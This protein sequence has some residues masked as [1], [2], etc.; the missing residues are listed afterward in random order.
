MQHCSPREN[1]TR[2]ELSLGRW[3]AT[4]PCFLPDRAQSPGVPSLALRRASLPSCASQQKRRVMATNYRVVG[5]HQ[6]MEQ[7]PQTTGY[8]AFGSPRGITLSIKVLEP[9]GC[10]QYTKFCW[11]GKHVNII[12]KP[13]NSQTRGQ[14]NPR[15]IRLKRGIWATFSHSTNI[16]SWVGIGFILLCRR[17]D[18]KKPNPNEIIRKHANTP[19]FQVIDTA[20]LQPA[21]NFSLR[22]TVKRR[23]QAERY[24]STT[25]VTLFDLH[26]SK[27]YAKSKM[28]ARRMRK[29]MLGLKRTHH[30]KGSLSV[31]PVGG[32]QC[33]LPFCFI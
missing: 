15:K 10:L 3:P 33:L 2:A 30:R 5:P 4:I 26:L 17:Q 25:T 7:Q 11:A 9:I 29:P 13:T 20:A 27:I 1:G 22:G 31:P 19:I 14:P 24:G 18:Y 28:G 32:T 8:A 16:L 23:S 21:G 12:M 6:T